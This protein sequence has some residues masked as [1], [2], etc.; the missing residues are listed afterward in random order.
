MGLCLAILPYF[1]YGS[2]VGCV[3]L[4]V[5]RLGRQ[6]QAMLQLLH[7]S[8]FLVLAALLVISSSLAVYRQEAW[9]Q[10]ANF[11]PYFLLWGALVLHLRADPNPWRSLSHWAWMLVKTTLP[12]ALLALVEYAIKHQAPNTSLTDTALWQWLYTG[13]LG[14][15]RSYSVFDYPNTLA[16]Y[17]VMVMGLTVGLLLKEVAAP[18]VRRYPERSLVLVG[19]LPLLLA[20]LYC[21]GSRNGYLVAT[22]LLLLSVCGARRHPWIRRLGWVGL[23]AIAVVTIF[24]GL[25]GRRPSWA[26]VTDDPRIAVWQLA[27]DLTRESPWWGHGLGSYKLLYDGSV[28]GHDFVAH[29]H[30]IWLM[31]TA[32]AGIPA[33]VVFTVAIGLICYR[34]IRRML[35]LTDAPK[36]SLVLGYSFC[37]L[38]SVLFSLFDVTLFDARI[39]IVGW[40]SLAILYAVPEIAAK[41]VQWD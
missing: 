17:L 7:R 35:A 16:N 9:L 20:A 23:G 19:T 25:E 11:L 3:G 24:L 41:P 4:M 29:A 21:S 15:L 31:L 6:P 39:N 34:G 1:M 8:G 12:V 32:E 14:H 40:L 18:T 10:L 26:W 28:P 5:W 38:A 33:M 13:N 27:W 2:I 22:V 36:R 37:F 30:N